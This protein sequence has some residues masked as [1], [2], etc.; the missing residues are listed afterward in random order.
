MTLLAVCSA[1]ID[2]SATGAWFSG[3]ATLAGVIVA[4]RALSTWREQIRLQDRYQK[5]DALLRSFI[6]CI[7]AGHDWQWDCGVGEKRDTTGESEKAHIWRNA[8]MD[9]RLAWKLAHPL[10]VGDQCDRLTA[11]PENLQSKIRGAGRH[12]SDP[13][14]GTSLFYKQLEKLEEEGEKEII[15][16]RD[17]KRQ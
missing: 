15:K 9:Y 10:F 3:F 4:C 1:E 14:T 6:L 8:L 5:A 17:A 2:W 12:L 11:H 7:R 13:P 16:R